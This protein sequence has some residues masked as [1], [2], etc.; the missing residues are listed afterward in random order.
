MI[1]DRRS[2]IT[3]GTFTLHSFVCN[4]AQQASSGRDQTPACSP[5]N[6]K[7]ASKKVRILM[8]MSISCMFSC[9]H[10]YY[11]RSRGGNSEK[12]NG[13]DDEPEKRKQQ[14]KSHQIEDADT[15]V[16]TDS[17]EDTPLHDRANP[18]TRSHKKIK[19]GT[20]PTPPTRLVP[21]L[22]SFWP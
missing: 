11:H 17:E 13:D 21:F 22:V 3:F 14:P 20:E 12:G 9:M 8:P 6:R 4:A 5:V 2:L 19:T 7:G 10:T 15:Q 18:P 1:C 16:A